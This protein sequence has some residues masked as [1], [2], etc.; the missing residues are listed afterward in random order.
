MQNKNKQHSL[1]TIIE[2]LGIHSDIKE[3]TLSNMLVITA[4]DQAFDAGFDL[5]K[6]KS[7]QK[8]RYKFYRIKGRR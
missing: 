2:V 8:S 6:T 4:L 5:G 3:C 1:K 7:I